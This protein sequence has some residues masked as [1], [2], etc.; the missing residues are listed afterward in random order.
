MACS[1][2]TATSFHKIFC[3]CRLPNCYFCI[4]LKFN[5]VKSFQNHKTIIWHCEMLLADALALFSFMI[6][7]TSHRNGIF[8]GWVC[9]I[10][11][12]DWVRLIWS[13]PND[14][15]YLYGM[16]ISEWSSKVIVI[17][18]LIF[19][20]QRGLGLCCM[21]FEVVWMQPNLIF[22]F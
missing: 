19:L 7:F 13:V 15:C 8:F 9:F 18:S 4:L 16:V 17:S 3:I 22:V 12:F 1:F 6:K 11:F 5:F 21:Y 2:L 10:F 14:S 20:N